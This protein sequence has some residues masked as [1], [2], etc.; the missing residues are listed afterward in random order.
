MNHLNVAGHLFE[1]SAALK[2]R[3][4]MLT[5]GDSLQAHREK[6][7]KI[8]LD[9]MYQFVGLLDAKGMLLEVNRAALEGAGI[10]LEDIQGKPF[11]LARWWQVS[12]ETMQRQKEVCARAAQGEFIRYDEEIYGQSGGDETIVIDYSLIPVK[13]DSGSVVFLLAEGRNITEKKKADAE[14]ARKNRELQQLLDRVKELD[15]IKNAFFANVS[16]ELRTP[17]ALILG[18]AEKT[19]AEGNYLKEEH[20]QNLTVVK[21]NAATL[22]KHVNDLL[23]ISKLDA[24]KMVANYAETDMARL[25]RATAGHFDALAADRGIKFVIDAPESLPAQVDPDKIE[26]VVLNLLSNAFKFTPPGGRIVLSL[27]LGADGN[28]VVMAV[29]DSGPGVK[30]QEQELI[31]ERFRQSDG[32]STR[33]FGGTGLGLA[34][35]RDFVGLHGGTISVMDAPVSGA[36]FQAEIPARAPDGR[37]VR[38]RHAEAGSSVEPNAILKGIIEELMPTAPAPA[39]QVS[40]A[41]GAMERACPT[42]LVVEDNQELNRF[43]VETLAAE[44]LVISASNGEEGLEQIHRVRPDLVV[45]DIMMPKMSGDQMIAAMRTN[46]DFDRIPV[47]VLSAKADDELRLRLLEHGAQDH[48]IKPFSGIELVTRVRNLVTMKR[49][50]DQLS[51][52]VALLEKQS[53]AKSEQLAQSEGLFRLMVENIKDYAIFM[54]D[55]KGQ[56]INWNRG[57]QRL[58]G[59]SEEEAVGRHYS[60]MYPPE[61]RTRLSPSHD[62]ETAGLQRQYVKE[63]IR[64]RKDGEKY[65]AEIVIS[66]MDDE[67]GNVVGFV[68]MI[69]DI[70][71][72]KLAD[73]AIRKSDSKLKWLVQSDILGVI[74]YRTDGTITE[75]N[76]AFLNIVGY[77]R[78]DIT[79]GIRLSWRAITPPEWEE[80]DRA[81]WRQLEEFGVCEPFEKEYFRKDGTRAAVYVCGATFEGSREEGFAYVLDISA[82]KKAEL[83]LKE[84]EA[85]FRTIANAM[86]QMV[87]STLPDG[88]HDYYNDQWYKFTGAPYGST[89]GEG[90]NDMFHPDDQERAWN[91]WRHSL[92][93]GEPY[94]IEYRLRH[95]SGDYRWTLGRALPVRDDSGAIVRWMGTCTD[96]H[97]QKL[98]QYA[99]QVS[100]RRKDEFLAMLAHELRNPLA[101][102]S[103]GAELL[104][105]GHLDQEGVKQISGVISRQATHMTGLIE[106]LLDVSRV[107]RGLVQIDKSE[108]DLKDVVSEA[109]EQVRPAMEGKSHHLDVHLTRQR[110][111]VSGDKKRLVQVL[112]NVLSNAAKFTPSGGGRISVWMNVTDTDVEVSV[113]DNGIGMSPELADQAF[114]LFVQSERTSDRSQ[115]GLGIGLALV[116]SLVHLHDG[117]VRLYSAG[118]QQGCEFTICLPRLQADTDLDRRGGTEVL[119]KDSAQGLR[120][121]AVDD[122]VDAANMLSMLLE[123]FGYAVFV[124]HHPA[125]AIELARRIRPEICILD[126][127]LPGFDGYELVRRLRELPEMEGVK[128]AALTGYGQPADQEK[129]LAAGFDCHFSKP[130]SAL[131][132][133][134]WLE[135]ASQRSPTIGRRMNN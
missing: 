103:S 31:F 43:I 90:W 83:A 104:S 106:D 25:L 96:I 82:I 62:L 61:E 101:P 29:Q 124:E 128:Y 89:D 50:Q 102:I 73:E 74:H 111:I 32:G 118:E 80:V 94:E 125:K 48:V 21:R 121:L 13:D 79:T 5:S 36:L 55:P 86:P 127:G 51:A 77:T 126:I 67:H 35:A 85:K 71:E 46:R 84:S 117:T 135:R 24:G 75:A 44:F 9:D 14:I 109:V 19:L 11:W 134:L 27:R 30:K 2:V 28:S 3:S 78:E 116:K 18:P 107:T 64:I 129:A 65:H 72:R 10:R 49:A 100:D 42:V 98:A 39:R 8:I 114:E 123:S 4:V 45:T 132:L 110:A 81:A 7:A 122:N 26:R 53:A 52:A 91:V 70:T 20:R 1:H 23:D 40:A 133:K 92:A 34:I 120:I 47:V 105:I 12:E 58:T 95:H 66:R 131:K 33:E 60:F 56:V 54:L 37:L 22:L 15:E 99:L 112:T 57:A 68:K 63:G 93:T 76:D 119:G 6:L 59:Y 16:H 41:D 88:F 115:G 69:R 87:W 108:V 38:S 97:D 17:L 113:R 130:A